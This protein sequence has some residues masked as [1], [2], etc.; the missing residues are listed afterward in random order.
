[1]AIGTKYS[2]R[3]ANKEGFEVGKTVRFHF[4]EK[5]LVV[6]FSRIAPLIRFEG[7]EVPE[8]QKKCAKQEHTSPALLFYRAIKQMLFANACG[9]YFGTKN[10][11]LAQQSQTP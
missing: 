9:C 1:L 4:W 3:E 7:Q 8:G 6:E 5:G 2:E 10:G 11:I